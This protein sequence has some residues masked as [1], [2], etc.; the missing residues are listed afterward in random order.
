[1]HARRLQP[2]AMAPRAEDPIRVQ[3]TS[4]IVRV[5]Q[6]VDGRFSS[7]VERVRDGVRTPLPSGLTE[8]GDML[9]R[10]LPPVL[11]RPSVSDPISD[12][13][14]RE[15]RDALALAFAPLQ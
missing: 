9:S 15:C 2:A 7:V 11:R 1:V 4:F 8:L 6:D 10:M 14:E 12:R 13:K 5:H 3:R